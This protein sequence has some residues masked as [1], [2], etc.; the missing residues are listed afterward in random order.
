MSYTHYTGFVLKFG[1]K[2]VTQRLQY[3]EFQRIIHIF[4]I[5]CKK[6]C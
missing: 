6:D 3:D 2:T 4:V 1:N 5:M